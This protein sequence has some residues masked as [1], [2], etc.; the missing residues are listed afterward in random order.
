VLGFA[1]QN[2][3]LSSLTSL[4]QIGCDLL[5]PIAAT[6]LMPVAA[7]KAAWSLFVPSDPALA[8][9]TVCQQVLQFQIANGVITSISGSNGLRSTIGSY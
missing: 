5:T 4:G 1:Q 6:Q 2:V 3:P 8:G 9:A 7:G